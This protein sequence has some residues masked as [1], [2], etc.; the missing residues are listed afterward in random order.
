MFA[1][2]KFRESEHRGGLGQAVPGSQEVVMGILSRLQMAKVRYTSLHHDQPLSAKQVD[3]S[4]SSLTRILSE[5][6]F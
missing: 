3:T 1:E 5:A 4:Q 6:V 2:R